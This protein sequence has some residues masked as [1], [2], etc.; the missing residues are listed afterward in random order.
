VVA[1][2]GQSIVRGSDMTFTTNNVPAATTTAATSVTSTSATLN[3]TVNPDGLPTNYDFAYG[4][5]SNNLT[6]TTPTTNLAAGTS[7]QN[8]SA[9]IVG[10][11]PGTTYYF[12]LQASNGAGPAPAADI[13]SFTTP[14]GPTVTTGAASGINPTT[15]VLNGTVD[16]AGQATT[17]HF[18]YGTDTFYGSDTP[19][20]SAGSGTS[21]VSVSA[22]I[23]GL[24]AATTYHFRLVGTNASGTTNGAD[25]TFTTPAAGSPVATTNAAT[26]V[27]SSGATLNGTVN[28]EGSATQA[29]FEWGTTTDYGFRTPLTDVGS[30]STD[31]AVSST[32]T[33]LVQGQTY[34]YRIKAMS[35]VG[36]S[37]GADMSFVAETPAT[38]T[39]TPASAVSAIDAVLNGTINPQGSATTYHFEWATSTAYGNVTPDQTLPADSTNHNVSAHIAGLSQGAVYH[40][41]LVASNGAG[42]V[43]GGDMTFV[44]CGACRDY[45]GDGHTDVFYWNASSGAT[46]L[47]LMGGQ[48]GVVK[49]TGV[50]IDPGSGGFP[51]LAWMPVANGDFNG[52]GHPD[53]LYWNQTN[54]NLVVWFMGGANGAVKQSGA[55]INPSGAFP[56]TAW[57]PI[58]VADFDG[59]GH[60]DI[61]YWNRTNGTTVVWFMGGANG[62][63]KQ[64][65][66]V[67]N[68]GSGPFPSTAWVPVAVN[69]FD[70]SGTADIL[71]WNRS[72]ASTVVWFM[73][74]TDGV[75][76][77]GGV[78]ID[79]GS[80]GFPSTAWV[81]LATGD[82]DLDG[83][84]DIF[85]WNRNTGRTAVWFMD[86]TTKVD[87]EAV[88]PGT[89][90][91]PSTAWRPVD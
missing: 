32:L 68:P 1:D 55:V 84:P 31:H 75:T 15:A 11:A 7:P 74:G 30:D 67:V 49:Q 89:A 88:N 22:P 58:S 63:V 91:F 46:A 65:G 86:G 62:I 48:D 16:P 64:K 2:N 12:Q 6:S 29:Q 77:Q 26:S 56:G 81:P 69:D 79:P 3:G 35:S 21:D 18:E 10:L 60:I 51:G 27:S 78:V 36:T 28:P 72:T 33:R 71:Y 38:V 9:N 52:D 39:T 47:W 54:G 82:F 34:H 13:L 44:A 73:G 45:N 61:L 87:G 8:V 76:K 53:I 25:A 41:R 66:E 20:S 19:A 57:V 17:Y 59:D 23:S 40:F 90:G 50:R 85:Y 4:T 43:N 42:T 24:T 37:Y 80:G 70:N 83:A 14:T 5:A